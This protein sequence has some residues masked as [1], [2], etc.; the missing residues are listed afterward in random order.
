MAFISILSR[1]V[2]VCVYFGALIFDIVFNN[3]CIY[4]ELLVFR[5]RNLGHLRI[6]SGNLSGVLII[7]IIR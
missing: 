1:Y 5:S 4:I 6:R 3:F 7:I 2:S